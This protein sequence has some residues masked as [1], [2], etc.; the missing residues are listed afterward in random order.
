[1]AREDLASKGVL[2]RRSRIALVMVAVVASMGA[3][4]AWLAAVPA[5]ERAG[6]WVAAG[7]TPSV[8]TLEELAAYP[9]AYR[10][11]MVRQ[12]DPE[13]KSKLWRAQLERYAGSAKGLT[14]DQRALIAKTIAM[15]GADVFARK[16]SS[17]ETSLCS[18]IKQTFP[19]MAAARPLRSSNIGAYASPKHSWMS[20][21]I[22]LQETVIAS[23]TLNANWA[24]DC[25]NEGWCECGTS[26]CCKNSSTFYYCNPTGA[27]DCGCV[28]E[29]A[30]PCNG[31]CRD[32]CPI[33]P[34]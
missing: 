13:V 17:K 29:D 20:R 8:S 14:D 9:E 25:Y 11:E 31:K 7:L 27:N 12:M 30:H 1:M 5:H 2:T 24:C 23:V 10:V 19:D 34:Q 28:W 4:T 15:A 32:N 21:I 26:D 18:Q 6:A 33:T 3:S 22:G 16:E